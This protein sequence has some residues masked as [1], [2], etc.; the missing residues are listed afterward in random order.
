MIAGYYYLHEN[1]D[2]IYKPGIEAAMDIRD[3]D[4][5]VGMWPVDPTNRSTAW[6]LLVEGLAAGAKSDHIRL[7]AAKWGCNDCDAVNY[8][9][10]IGCIL[11]VD[12]NQKTATRKDF[13]NL[14]ESPCGFGETYLEAMAGLAKQLGYKPG[15]MW[16]P[17]FID[18]LIGPAKK[19]MR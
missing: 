4:F 12:G 18:L 15:K 14:Q 7:L 9:D 10:R 8:A 13:V 16:T 2:L 19:A 5:A 6:N 17:K 11:V 1:G 3:S